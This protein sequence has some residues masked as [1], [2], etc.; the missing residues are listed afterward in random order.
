MHYK[1][2]HR[3]ALNLSDKTATKLLCEL[4]Q[5]GLIERKSV[6]GRESLHAFMS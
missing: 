5:F 4:E 6:R 2:E 1:P 3:K